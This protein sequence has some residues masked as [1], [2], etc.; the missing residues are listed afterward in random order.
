MKIKKQTP[1][2]KTMK[3]TLKAVKTKGH[4]LMK[5]NETEWNLT[6]ENK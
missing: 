3:R 5:R 4:K 2:L 1:K 6:D